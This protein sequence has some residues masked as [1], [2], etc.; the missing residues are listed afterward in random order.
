MLWGDVAQGE[1]RQGAQFGR[2]RLRKYQFGFIT[3]IFVL[4][5]NSEAFSIDNWIGEVF[6]ILVV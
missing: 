5:T 4:L 1:L 2:V 6:R 3:I